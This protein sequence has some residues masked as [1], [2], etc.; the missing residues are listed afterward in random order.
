M[1]WDNAPHHPEV[2]P[3]HLHDGTVV[4]PTHEPTLAEIL[5]MIGDSM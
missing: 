5:K 1:R 2:A 3:D 4:K